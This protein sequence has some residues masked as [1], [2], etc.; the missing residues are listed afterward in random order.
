WLRQRSR[1]WETSPDQPTAYAPWEWQPDQG[2]GPREPSDPRQQSHATTRSATRWLL[3]DA[4][5][6]SSHM[7]RVKTRQS[8]QV[9][10]GGYP[11]SRYR[12]QHASTNLSWRANHN[13][14]PG[15]VAL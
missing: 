8:T 14:L 12:W 4:T 7:T 10:D 1:R 15:L 11:R 3:R 6:G 13:S 9:P 5:Y 2:P